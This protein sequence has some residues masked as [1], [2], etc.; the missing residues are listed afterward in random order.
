[1][2][3][4]FLVVVLLGL[5]GGIYPAWRASSLEPIEALRYEGGSS[6]E[7]VRRLPFGGM[8]VQSLWQRSTRTTL[9]LAVIG[10]TVGG[11]ILLESI[12]RS[13]MNDYMAMMS[14]NDVE[15]MVRQADVSDT[16]L[17][18]IDE[19][20]GDR[21]AAMPE[22]ASVGGSVFSA[23][24]LPEENSFFLIQGYEPDG[25]AKDHFNIVEGHWLNG[26][27]QLVLG[28]MM[29]E[30][31]NKKVGDMIELSGSR[32]KV[33]GILESGI[34]WEEMGG[35]I[36]LRDAQN[37][38]GRPRKVT[39]YSV[40]LFQP[41]TAESVAAKINQEDPDIYAALSGEFMG[42]LPD[43][44]AMD[45]MF[46]AISLLTIIVG[47]LGVMNTMLMS[48]LE[49]TREIGVL[50]ALG[51]KQGMVLGMIM[52]ESLLL[53]VFGGI[54]GILVAFLLGMSLRVIPVYGIILTTV[55]EWDLL[56]RALSISLLLGLAGG[57]YPALRATRLQPVEALQL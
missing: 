13:M 46:W 17:S 15:I 4:A 9:T 47:G 44:K 29:A 12:V 14:G 16:S 33:V 8:A 42:E 57:L 37:F 30:S 26:N 10:L 39:L 25:F 28:R 19:R 50:R 3:Q 54:A 41:S 2:G 5:V 23:I 11:I 1:M 31:L 48:V 22:V 53:G 49:R 27:R 6:G 45:A 20:V 40:N 36:T 56:I 34:G 55:W 43:M 38:V 32:F 51:W 35:V 24:T 18:A 7:N 52:R 21:I